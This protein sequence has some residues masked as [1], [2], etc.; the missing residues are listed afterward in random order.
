MEESLLWKINSECTALP[1]RTK[2][3]REFNFFV[4]KD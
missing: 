4:L 3:R 2:K 1:D